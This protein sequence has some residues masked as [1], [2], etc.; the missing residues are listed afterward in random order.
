MSWTHAQSFCVKCSKHLMRSRARIPQITYSKA[1][2]REEHRNE[3]H[4]LCVHTFK[5]SGIILSVCFIT[6]GLWNLRSE[7]GKEWKHVSFCFGTK[8]CLEGHPNSGIQR[9][10]HRSPESFESPRQGLD[11][12]I[13]NVFTHKTWRTSLKSHNKNLKKWRGNV[14]NIQ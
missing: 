12:P 2:K 14:K 6:G 7:R 8:F 9:L 13:N 11:D 10:C 3:L 5:H 4:S 1:K